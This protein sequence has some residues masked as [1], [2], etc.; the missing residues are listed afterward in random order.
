MTSYRDI[1]VIDARAPRFNQATVGIL[2]LVAVLT[3]WWLLLGLLAVQL[4]DGSNEPGETARQVP[5]TT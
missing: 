1:D 5:G 2:S 3:G 4:G